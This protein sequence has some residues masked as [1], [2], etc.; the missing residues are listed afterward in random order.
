MRFRGLAFLGFVVVSLGASVASATVV[1]VTVDPWEDYGGGCDICGTAY[2]A[3]TDG[4]L[5]SG[6]FVDPT[7]VGSVITNISVTIWGTACGAGSEIE[8]DLEGTVIASQVD[9]MEMTCAC[10]DCW[11][12][13]PYVSADYPDGFP[14]YVGGG[15]N[16]V[17]FT[18][19]DF[20]S[21]LYPGE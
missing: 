1:Q 6:T 7:P 9:D 17:N 13:S 11:S 10:G 19:I 12:S 14:G 5:A 4:G 16:T 3:C 20:C 18:M 8:V 21:N 2:S 15:D